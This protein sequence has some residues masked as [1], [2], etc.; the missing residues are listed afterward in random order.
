MGVLVTLVLLLVFTLRRRSAPISFNLLETAPGALHNLRH[1]R[2][3]RHF[4]LYGY[5]AEFENYFFLF[6]FF[7]F[8][9]FRHNA[10]NLTE[11]V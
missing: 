4:P 3:F 5:H 10:G 11:P 1:L 9:D 8:K 6:G 2:H 7:F